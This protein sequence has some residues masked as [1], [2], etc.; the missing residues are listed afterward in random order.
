MQNIRAQSHND[1][2]SVCLSVSQSPCK[3]HAL[4]ISHR[5]REKQASSV[6]GCSGTMGRTLNFTLMHHF[7]TFLE[8]LLGIS[9]RKETARS[10]KINKIKRDT[11]HFELSHLH[12]RHLSAG[13]KISFCSVQPPKRSSCR[14]FFFKS[15]KLASG[16]KSEAQLGNVSKAIMTSETTEDKRTVLDTQRC[17]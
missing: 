1:N 7:S 16:W 9:K 2:L 17:L 5:S 12:V 10:F 6:S 4:N 13:A 15:E 14:V 3:A 8:K 11:C